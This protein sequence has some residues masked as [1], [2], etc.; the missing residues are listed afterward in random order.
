MPS[1][2]SITSTLI[3]EGH[4]HTITWR[5][6]AVVLDDHDDPVG[7]LALCAL[8]AP[9]PSCIAV[10]AAVRRRFD[11]VGT[12]PVWTGPLPRASGPELMLKAWRDL[13][14]ARPSTAA[15][16]DGALSVEG[17]EDRWAMTT[18][19][20]L[21]PVLRRRLA[22]DA[23]IGRCRRSGSAPVQPFGVG[24]TRRGFSRRDG[25]G[26]LAESLLLASVGAPPGAG[27]RWLLE[28]AGDRR[29]GRL[30]DAPVA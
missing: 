19:G 12:W 15:D 14:A 29:A 9:W 10:L 21:E 24:G 27:L 30:R 4:E 1:R 11:P 23:V 25:R 13:Q 5:D 6:G 2:S 7:E 16:D 28:D 26:P 20:L 3:C 22:L 18:L 8:G 17:A